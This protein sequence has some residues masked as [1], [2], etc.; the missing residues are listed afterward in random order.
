[1]RVL[2]QQSE[3]HVSW[4]GHQLP[5]MHRIYSLV[6][7]EQSPHSEELK[8]EALGRFAQYQVP[9]GSVA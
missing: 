4:A 2:L 5:G 9:L 1:M 7:G 3:G 6:S 8:E